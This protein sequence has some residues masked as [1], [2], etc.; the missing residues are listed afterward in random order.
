M[1]N[2]YDPE[3][4]FFVNKF[5]TTKSS[6]GFNFKP[7]LLETRAATKAVPDSQWIGNRFAQSSQTKP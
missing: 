5:A 7:K 6:Y 3:Y 4:L 1:S 2:V